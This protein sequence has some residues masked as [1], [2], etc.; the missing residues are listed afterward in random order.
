MSRSERLG[1]LLLV[2]DRATQSASVELDLRFATRLMAD[3]H[4]KGAT[5]GGYLILY[6]RLWSEAA[7][8]TMSAFVITAI[9]RSGNVVTVTCAGHPVAVGDYVVIEDVVGGT[10]SFNGTFRVAS[11]PTA[12]T[13]TYSQ[14]GADE[15]GSGGH[16][17]WV[18]EVPAPTAVGGFTHNVPT[19][20]QTGSYRCSWGPVAQCVRLALS[21]TDGQ[22]TVKVEGQE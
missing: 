5:L 18:P 16:F 3:H 15:S 1:P 20:P 13:F 2:F 10:T 11:T 9:A 6:E 22:H 7:A 12:A 21:V 8:R 14:T 19:T 17:H 4:I